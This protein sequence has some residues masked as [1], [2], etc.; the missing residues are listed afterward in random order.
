M[1][2]RFEAR[3]ID[4]MVANGIRVLRVSLGIVFFWFG[5]LKLLPG[6]S[7]AEALAGATIAKLTFGAIAPGPASFALGLAEGA[8]GVA[9]V[10][11]VHLRAALALLFVQMGGT[12]TPLVLFPAL[13]FSR[14][15]F[16]PTL[17]GQYIVKNLV[18][19]S[20]AIVI[21]ATLRGARLVE[22]AV[23]SSPCTAPS[24]GPLRSS[25]SPS[26]TP[27][28]GSTHVGP[29]LSSPTRWCSPG[30]RP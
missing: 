24:P 9:L 12:L 11:G 17:E 27:F 23:G 14:L 15:P 13:T 6:T 4:W 29:P 16:V 10:L 2:D 25:S 19:V 30:S 8:I 7:P 28:E 18:L 3:M 5:V 20:A 22:R 1:Y 21:G 26:A